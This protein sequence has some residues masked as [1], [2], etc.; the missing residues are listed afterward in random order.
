MKRLTKAEQEACLRRILHRA[1]ES[2]YLRDFKAAKERHAQL[3]ALTAQRDALL[4]AC[5]TALLMC[6]KD[7]CGRRVVQPLL[8]AA[9]ALCEPPQTIAGGE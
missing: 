4:K 5:K 9:I 2:K 1:R 3:E 7:N 8:R 6:E